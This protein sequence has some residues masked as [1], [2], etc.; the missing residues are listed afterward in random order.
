MFLFGFLAVFVITQMHGVGLSRRTRTVLGVAY[1]A[2]VAGVF[3]WRG[4]ARLFEVTWIP[5]IEYTLV[6]VVAFLVWVGIKI[7][8]AARS[9]S[10]SADLESQASSSRS[11]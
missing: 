10:G 11:A 5:T 8:D 4:W 1:L 7:V 3:S 9:R 6:G 2:A